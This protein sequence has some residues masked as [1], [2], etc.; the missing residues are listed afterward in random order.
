MRIKYQNTQLWCECQLVSIWNACRYWGLNYPVMGT[1]EYRASC[2]EARAIKGAAVNATKQFRKFG[3]TRS[4]GYY[5][6]SWVRYNLPVE[7]SVFCHRGYH[8]VLA[9]AADDD[10]VLLANYA[11]GITYWLNWDRLYDISNKRVKPVQF[12]K[13]IK[14]DG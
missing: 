10:R 1:K 6:L 5:V 13:G 3:I 9:V 8:S 12:R 14:W 11:Y 2:A 4:C 7:F